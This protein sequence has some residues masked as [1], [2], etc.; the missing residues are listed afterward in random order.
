VAGSLP[1]RRVLWLLTERR[2]V[3]NV[4]E[5]VGAVRY[6]CDCGTECLVALRADCDEA[7]LEAVCAAG[8]ALGMRVVDG[9]QCSFVCDS[10][11]TRHARDDDGKDT[12]Q[13]VGFHAAAS[14]H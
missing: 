2:T 14:T 11:G 6:R 9:R 13:L 5:P 4:P 3:E 7:W 12:P 1:Q 8:A 10:C